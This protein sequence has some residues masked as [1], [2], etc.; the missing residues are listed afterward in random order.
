M[1]VLPLVYSPNSLLKKISKPVEKVDDELRKLMDDMVQTMYIEEGLGLAAVQVGHLKRVL[2]MDVDYEHEEHH[3]H[4]HGSCGGIHV[5]N[6]NPRYF[7]N[8]EILEISEELSSYNEGCLSFPGA[9]AEV[10]RPQEVR[11]KFLDYHGKEQVVNLDGIMATCIQH[12]ID[13]LNG[14]TFVDHI[15]ALKRDVI[16]K[17]MRK[18]K[19]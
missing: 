7:V 14:I 3:H 15:S 16:L 12:E 9:R 6:T 8:P 13:H 17:K 2:V 11:V 18:L 1:T 19:S 5:K 10:T 4:D